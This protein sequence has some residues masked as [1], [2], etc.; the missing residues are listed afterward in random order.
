MNLLSYRY[1]DRTYI[2]NF[3]E[4][5]ATPRHYQ[6]I[7][8]VTS[9]NCVHIYVGS[10]DSLRNLILTFT[11][12][13]HFDNVLLLKVLDYGQVDYEQHLQLCAVLKGI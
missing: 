5:K 6:P 4:K 8:L 1:L 12:S 11:K 3:I 2:K 10:C 7:S 9:R 13:N